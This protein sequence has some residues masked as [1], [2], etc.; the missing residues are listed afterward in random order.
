MDPL[1]E[2]P[3]PA[4]ARI[5]ARQAEADEQLDRI[6]RACHGDVATAQRLWGGYIEL[7]QDD[8]RF[9][10]EQAR[11]HIEEGKL[12]CAQ[13]VFIAHGNEYCDALQ[14]VSELESVLGRLRDAMVQHYGEHV[15]S[16]VQSKG[17]QIME[18]AVAESSRPPE[19]DEELGGPVL[20]GD[21]AFWQA[22]GADFREYNTAE[23]NS[24]LADWESMT[25]GWSFRGPAEA[26]AVLKSLATIAAKGFQTY[27]ADEPW[28]SWL[29][30]LRRRRWNYKES[31]CTAGYSQRAMEDPSRFGFEPP[32]AKG[33]LRTG[34]V[35]DQEMEALFGPNDAER[36][37]GSS[38][39]Q[40][41]FE[42]VHGVVDR[43]FDASKKLCLKLGARAA[44]PG[45]N[46]PTVLRRE[47]LPEGP[48]GTEVRRN[49]RKPVRRNT[50]HE[51]IDQVLCE[52]AEMR[53]QSHEEVFRALDKR[54]PLP[55]A[56]PFASARGWLAGFNSDEHSA[57]VWL[58]KA[59][60]RLHL[61]PFARG[62]KKK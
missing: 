29:D 23:N 61:P 32:M 19:V 31:Q 54:A 20:V 8:L 39:V 52:I 62:P 26:E 9:A 3:E 17:A 30:E 33:E 46:L 6:V 59:W 24:L 45:S 12:L 27:D 55:K 42:G 53:P 5:K 15:R 13:Y 58:S 38:F 4:K 51:K 40:T 48:T 37:R 60:T 43:L 57:R 34:T 25:D 11:A 2:L 35:D 47:E 49:S 1:I 36:K 22:C 28:R 10:F 56:Q 21:A 14:D 50:V 18:R 7:H 16:A 41:R 44:G